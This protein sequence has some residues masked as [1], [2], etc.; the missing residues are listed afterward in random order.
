M[1]GRKRARDEDQSEEDGGEPSGSRT[2]RAKKAKDDGKVK[3]PPNSFMCFRKAHSKQIRAENPEIKNGQVST[4]LGQRWGSMTEAQKKPYE[5]EADEHARLAKLARAEQQLIPVQSAQ[6]A[7]G[8][9]MFREPAQ[10]PRELQPMAQDHRYNYLMSGALPI[11]PPQHSQLSQEA[12]PTASDRQVNSTP[13][14]VPQAVIHHES[15]QQVNFNPV[16]VPRETATSDRNISTPG[17]VPEVNADH[18]ASSF[19]AESSGLFFNEPFDFD[20]DFGLINNDQPVNND[21]FFFQNDG[22]PIND[23]DLLSQ[24]DD[25]LLS[26]NDDQ[27]ANI[28]DLAQNDDQPINIEDLAQNDGQFANIDDLFFQNDGQSANIDDL[29]F[30]NDGQPV[31]DD[32]LL[33]QNDGQPANIDDLPAQNDGQLDEDPFSQNYDQILFNNDPSFLDDDSWKFVN[34]DGN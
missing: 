33:F 15:D 19:G 22:Q 13:D 32:S 23:G 30:Q 8:H 2:R 6:P 9:Q 10:Q 25:D 17:I 16:D 14:F 12:T 18:A 20:Y 26:Q 27:P 1:H 7:A 11:G 3:K 28:E 24:N 34:L 31:F 4:I 5:E 29:F 21:D